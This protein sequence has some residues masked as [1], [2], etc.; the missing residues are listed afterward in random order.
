MKI[1]DKILD[2][3]FPPV[4]IC[5]KRVLSTKAEVPFCQD[6]FELLPTCEAKEAKDLNDVNIAKCYC[7]YRYNEY[8]VKGIIF[9]TKNYYSKRY[10]L[11]VANE[12]RKRLLKHN[13]LK[14]INLLA[15]CPRKKSNIKAAGFDQAEEM[16]KYLSL[17]TSIPYDKYILRKR[18]AKDQ[19]FLNS[20]E[21]LENVKNVYAFNKDKCVNGKVVLLLDDVVTTG[22]TVKACA[23]LLKENGAKAVYV[24]SIAD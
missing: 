3:L 19:K 10:A 14:Q 23:K 13:L 1:I 6:C 15:Y 22:A 7:L 21:R 11:F 24:M 16:A 4:C 20:R 9:H 18:K 2:F 8:D 17:A 12:M 5:C